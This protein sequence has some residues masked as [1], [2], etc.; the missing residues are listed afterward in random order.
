MM[1]PTQVIAVWGAQGAGKSSFIAEVSGQAGSLVQPWLRET[2]CNL[3][4][5]RVILAE[6]PSLDDAEHERSAAKVVHHL[7]EWI[8]DFPSNGRHL[9]GFIFLHDITGNRY[10]GSDR[11]YLRILQNLCGEDG[12]RN[13]LF[14]TTKWF[15]THGNIAQDSF[16]VYSQ[17]LHQL[18]NV[19]WGNFVRDGA[20]VSKWDHPQMARSIVENCCPFIEGAVTGLQKELLVEGKQ[21]RDTAV[22]LFLLEELAAQESSYADLQLEKDIASHWSQLQ[23]MREDRKLLSIEEDRKL[24]SIKEDRKLLMMA[25][26]EVS[27][28]QHARSQPEQTSL[29]KTNLTAGKSSQ[30]PSLHTSD[31]STVLENYGWIQVEN[32]RQDA[33]THFSLETQHAKPPLSQAIV[34]TLPDFLHD[35]LELHDTFGCDKVWTCTPLA[36]TPIEKIPLTIGGYPVVIP[37]EYQYPPMALTLPPPDPH[38][39]FIDSSKI[40]S[41][42][43]VNDIFKTY[44]IVLGFY[45][46]INGMLQVIV[47]DDFDYEYALS[48][49]PN[50]FGGLRVSYIPQSFI[51]TADRSSNVMIA[52]SQ[53]ETNIQPGSASSSS[54]PPQSIRSSNVA[55]KRAQK[56]ECSL[57]LD[58][59]STVEAHVERSKSAESFRGKIGLMTKYDNHFY[60]VVSSHVLTNALIAAKSEA[61]PGPEWTKAVSLVKPSGASKVHIGNICETFDPD[62]NKFPHGFQHDVSLVEVA[63]NSQLVSNI[64]SP[65]PTTWLD[66]AG[67]RRIQLTSQSLYLLDNPKIESKSI[68]MLTHRYQM[69]G[70]AWFKTDSEAAK[71]T[72]FRFPFHSSTPSASTE[73]YVSFV[74][75][76]VLYRIDP[77]FLP[78]GAHS[79]TAVCIHEDNRQNGGGN[80]GTLH[81]AKVAG[82][83]SWAQPGRGPQRLDIDPQKLYQRLEER[84]LA[85][86]G[87]LQVPEGLRAHEV[88]S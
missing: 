6:I 78:T 24:L 57:R 14:V 45:I 64:K 81:E 4:G 39:L 87:A 77:D 8:E 86:Y 1:P 48:H 11:R 67:W 31:L 47:P 35:T 32:S 69:V 62:A 33:S 49:R 7:A 44:D 51:S 54:T 40:I 16:G 10:S 9:S 68:A 72:I 74:S 82:F 73:D 22:G 20:R 26:E 52:P 41:E 42:D 34:D 66:Q 80:A 30:E 79:G 28:G 2:V 76:S 37:V 43:I 21:L 70:Q 12:L 84:G 18:T 25:R 38:P 58:F 23:S 83:S 50:S 53:P 29:L 19:F 61:F 15:N 75:N 56:S 55:S 36:D 85:F 5:R 88:V 17:R 71:R 13:V 46:L 59:G 65:V 63:G 27:T 3:N 60:L